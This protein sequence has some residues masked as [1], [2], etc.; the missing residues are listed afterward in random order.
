MAVWSPNC[1]PRHGPLRFGGF[2]RQRFL[3]QNVLAGFDAADGLLDVPATSR[4]V[5]QGQMLRATVWMLREK[6]WMLRATVWMLRAIGWMWAQMHGHAATSRNVDH[7]QML[8]AIVWMLRAIVWMLR[9][10]GWMLR[11][12][13][14]MLRAI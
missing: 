1:T 3:A 4:N 8:R 2:E 13:V 5:D 7:G 10:K 6:V 14:W 12:I 9:E 11:A